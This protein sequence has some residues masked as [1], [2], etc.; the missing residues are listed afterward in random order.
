MTVS[1]CR[2]GDGACRWLSLGL[3][4]L[5]SQ[6]AG[7]EIPERGSVPQAFAPAGRPTA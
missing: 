3:Q 7:L 5:A 1:P 2:F 4:V 6:R